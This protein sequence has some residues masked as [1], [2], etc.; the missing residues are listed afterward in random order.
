MRECLRQV[1][2]VI[3]DTSLTCEK[4]NKIHPFIGE[5]YTPLTYVKDALS[6]EAI[7]LCTAVVQK[8][9]SE[10]PSEVNVGVK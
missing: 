7:Y 2:A 10:K 5:W 1:E 6:S 8:K 3:T 9:K 4:K